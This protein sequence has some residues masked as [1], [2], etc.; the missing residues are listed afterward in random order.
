MNKPNP[1]MFS[2]DSDFTYDSGI[3]FVTSLKDIANKPEAPDQLKA[4]WETISEWLGYKEG[5]FTESQSATMGN[6]WKSYMALGVAP[7]IKLQKSF[8][9]SSKTIKASGFDTKTHL[10]PKEVLQVFDR[11][12]A[13]EEEIQLKRKA[14]LENFKQL[15]GSPPKNNND[16]ASQG[17][18]KKNRLFLIFTIGWVLWVILRTETRFYFLGHRFGRWDD[19]YY[20]LNLIAPPLALF[21]TDYLIKWVKRADN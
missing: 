5:E 3:F 11:L 6:A 21:L 1:L 15:L 14:D 17:L 13:T 19:D 2:P 8:S 20:L 4:D 18:S 16:S 12:M 9:V 7:S 10:P